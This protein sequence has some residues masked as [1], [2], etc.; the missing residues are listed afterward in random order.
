MSAPLRK[1]AYT[2]ALSAPD[3]A[4]HGFS[5]WA[6]NPLNCPAGLT[7]CW[8]GTVKPTPGR[9]SFVGADG[10]QFIED[11]LRFI[12]HL[13]PHLAGGDGAEI[14]QGPLFCRFGVRP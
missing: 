6:V 9:V 5:T 8:G 4:A 3:E 13:C 11:E 14:G 12:N 7:C 2:Y 1:I 10:T